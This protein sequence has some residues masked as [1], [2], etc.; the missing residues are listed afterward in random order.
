MKTF[1]GRKCVRT[2]LNLALF[3]L[4]SLSLSYAQETTGRILGIVTDETGSAVPEAKIVA[5]SPVSPRGL[6]ATSD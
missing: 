4:V 1:C 3:S 2:F 5:T 6:E